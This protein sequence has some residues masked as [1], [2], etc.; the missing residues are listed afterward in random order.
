VLQAP[1]YIVLDVPP[2]IAEQVLAIRRRYDRNLARFP[3]EITVAGTSGLG[4]LSDAQDAKQV[5]DIVEIVGRGALP[6]ETSFVEISRFAGASVFWLRPRDRAPFDALQAALLNSG[7]RFE[8]S[9]FAYEPHCTL[10]G[11]ASL[12]PDEEAR[13]LNEPFPRHKFTIA[14][15]SLYQK[16]NGVPSLLRTFP[17]NE[18]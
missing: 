15:L 3:V 12:T 18:P 8:S 14:Q 2:D 9:A 7:L 16:L 4:V 13:L 17:F 5:C 6:I 10:S 11:S 1:T